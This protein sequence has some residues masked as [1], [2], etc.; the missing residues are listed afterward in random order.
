[1]EFKPKPSP[2]PEN[3]PS[4]VSWS[5][6]EA[7]LPADFHSHKSVKKVLSIL[8]HTLKESTV[9]EDRTIDAPLLFF[10]LAFREVSRAM[11]R[12]GRGPDKYPDHL[13]DS[14]LGVADSER[15]EEMMESITLP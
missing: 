3:Y 2:I 15:M 1:M 6:K 10:G 7:Y 4:W 8:R 13:R 14:T 11:E 12:E 5:S 9:F